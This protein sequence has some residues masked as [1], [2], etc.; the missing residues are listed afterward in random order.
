MSGFAPDIALAIYLERN[1]FNNVEFLEMRETPDPSVYFNG[2][3]GTA[4]CYG[5]WRYVWL[6][7][8][9]RQND[10][11]KCDIDLQERKV[12]ICMNLTGLA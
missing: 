12:E 2:F 8:I 11:R 4:H 10:W 3:R 7:F 5:R 9:S 1:W 6:A